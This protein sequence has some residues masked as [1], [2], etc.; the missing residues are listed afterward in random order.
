VLAYFG[1]SAAQDSGETFIL[2]IVSAS[3][4]ASQRFREFNGKSQ[5]TGLQALPDGTAVLAQITVRRS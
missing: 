5:S 3:Q 1:L 4:D 2:M